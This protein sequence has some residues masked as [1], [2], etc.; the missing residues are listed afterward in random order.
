MGSG[1]PR[2]AFGASASTVAPHAS[3]ARE[4]PAAWK[5][6]LAFVQPCRV[7]GAG[8]A[9]HIELRGLSSMK[10]FAAPH[11]LGIEYCASCVQGV[12]CDVLFIS[13]VG[14][15]SPLRK[16][17]NAVNSLRQRRPTC[18]QRVPQRQALQH[19][20]SP[21]QCHLGL[22]TTELHESGDERARVDD[23]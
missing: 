15:R 10:N 21:D 11:T 1:W 12:R 18:C 20:D 4:S 3:R 5:R 17:A 23:H 19:E 22:A 7:G 9:Y 14:S 2:E 16:S 13:D 6:A 8:K